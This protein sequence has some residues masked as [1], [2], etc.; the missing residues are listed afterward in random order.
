LDDKIRKFRGAAAL[1][2]LIVTLTSNSTGAATLKVI[3]RDLS[4]ETCFK[5]SREDVVSMVTKAVKLVSIKGPKDA[6]R[7]FMMP[8]GGYIK[9]DLYVF[10]LDHSGTIV[11]NG[12]NPH[13][14]GNN[15]LQLHDRNGHYFIKSILY[16]A[17]TRGHGWVDYQWISPCTGKL[18]S[19]SA[20]FKKTGQFVIGVGFY[21]ALRPL[22]NK[23]HSK[24]WMSAEARTAANLAWS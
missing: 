4:P 7:Q 1:L 23:F 21:D 22:N 20:Y 5:G 14:V 17:S 3:T 10:V 8:E 13:S 9:G 18:S 12:A 15:V 19:K 24:T 6:F 2:L 11:A 16:Q